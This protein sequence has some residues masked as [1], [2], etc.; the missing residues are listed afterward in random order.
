MRST[1]RR[2]LLRKKC[3]RLYRHPANIGQ[4][5]RD[6][7]IVSKSPANKSSP[8]PTPTASSLGN[9]NKSKFKTNRHETNSRA[10]ARA[11]VKLYGRRWHNE[12]ALRS[13]GTLLLRVRAPAGRGEERGAESLRSHCGLAIYQ[14]KSKKH[15]RT[16]LAILLCN[17]SLR[18]TWTAA[19]L[20]AE[21]SI[22][23]KWTWSTEEEEEE[24]EEEEKEEK[25]EDDD[26]EEE[27]EEEEEKEEEE[28][29]EE[30]E[31][32]EKKKK[33]EEEEEEAEEEREEEEEEEEN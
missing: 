18:V 26:E 24:E 15:S 2:S 21:R 25:E 8:T 7:L 11:R 16:H 1:N 28:K 23:M 6:Q 12:S 30:E 27:E 29:E 4:V 32:E 14:N 13:V 33:E 3:H 19:G 9:P 10:R 22:H 17:P 5:I 20:M 31:G